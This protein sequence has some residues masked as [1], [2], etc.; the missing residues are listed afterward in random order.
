[1]A[2]QDKTLKLCSCNKTIPLDAKALGAALKSG[3]AIPVHTELCRKEA[4]SFQGALGDSEVLVACTQ[5][6][7][8][9]SEIAAAAESKAE[10]R[11]VN[12]REAAGWSAEGRQATPKIAALLAAAALPEPAPVPSVEYKSGGQ[13]LVIGPSAAAL[14]WAQRLSATLEPSVLITRGEGGE[15]PAARSYP[16]WSGQPRGVTGWLG[17]FEV[18]WEQENAIDLELCTRCNACVEACPENAIDFT[19]Q[20]DMEKCRSHRACVKAC[21]AIGAVD[22]SRAD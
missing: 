1:M 15:L 12:I 10:L 3:A 21:G 7:P 11:F 2:I 16:V 13:I 8:L 19:Y 5:E 6:A 14:D 4:A 22:F 18:E 20:I 9:F 17:A